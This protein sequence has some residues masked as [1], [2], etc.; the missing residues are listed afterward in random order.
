MTV[1]L[2]LGNKK[3]LILFCIFSLAGLLI[4]IIAHSEKSLHIIYFLWKQPFL[5][6]VR[7]FCLILF[8]FLFLKRFNQKFLS[9][10]W[11]KLICG[12]I[13]LPVL[14]LPV[15]RCY[16]KIPYIFC[17]ACPDKCPWGL[18]RS[19]FFT[20][21]IALNLS[22]RFWCTACCPFGTFQECLA[23]TSK[24]RLRFFSW[25][26]GSAYIVLFLAAGM[27][28]LSFFGMSWQGVFENGEYAWGVVTVFVAVLLITAVFFIPKAFCR[29]I[30][31]VGTIAELNNRLRGFLR[32]DKAKTI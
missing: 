4:A 12:I 2:S 11:L 9:P 30:C 31:P 20:S 17:R 29:Y 23:Q 14:L 15:L 16:F 25:V 27:Y 28:F 1:M 7:I 19:L 21:F 24:K 13:F 8:C 5:V 22:G 32:P 6:S 18:S 26:S 10:Y 3:L